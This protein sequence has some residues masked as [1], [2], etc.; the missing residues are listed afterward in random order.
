MEYVERRFR[1]GISFLAFDKEMA[2][3]LQYSNVNVDEIP[4][5]IYFTNTI[6][7]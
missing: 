5:T 3:Q 2:K 7:R 6:D 4:D 1:I